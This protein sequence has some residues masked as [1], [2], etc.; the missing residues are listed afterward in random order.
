[1]LSRHHRDGADADR[2]LARGSPC[3]WDQFISLDLHPHPPRAEGEMIMVADL[4]TFQSV[5]LPR[6]L[7]E[8]VQQNQETWP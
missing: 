6:A 4:R 1:M 8:E 3:R 2:R 7:R 5:L